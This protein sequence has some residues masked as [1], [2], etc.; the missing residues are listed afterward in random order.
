[1]KRQNGFTL[2]ELL[3]VIGIIALLISILLPAL[4]KARE[5]A[6]ALACLSNERQIATA[7]FMYAG[8]N[9][10]SLPNFSTYG[11]GV[12]A[13]YWYMKILPYLGAKLAPSGQTDV[14][15]YVCPSRSGPNAGTSDYGLSALDY[16]V[17]YGG[18]AGLINYANY[19]GNP[20][21]GS[22][23]LT[24]VRHPSQIFLL[25]DT[26]TSYYLA[27][28]GTPLSFSLVYAPYTP[29]NGPAWPLDSD[30]DHDG[31]NDSSSS[32]LGVNTPYNGAAARHGKGFNVAFL[33]GHAAF[34]PT[35]EWVLSRNWTW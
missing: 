11:S 29:N 27:V 9:R 31:I 7:I 22:V 3:V 5:S 28:Y 24:K 35:S 8:E 14:G 1:M 33:D 12:E 30:Y 21:S 20:Q 23:K 13:D 19:P 26:S 34:V 4:N 32:F 16:G 15:V 6:K 17:N 25:M 2:V 18:D 10:Q